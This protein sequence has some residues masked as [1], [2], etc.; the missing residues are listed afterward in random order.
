MMLE[1][2]C[3]FVYIIVDVIYEWLIGEKG[4]FDMWIVYVD[5]IGLKEKWIK[6]FVIMDQDGVNV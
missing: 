2:W 4:Y 5:E 6:W 3:C 1:N